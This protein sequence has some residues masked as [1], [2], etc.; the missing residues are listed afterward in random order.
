MS[1]NH[2]F[3]ATF[4]EKLALF[5]SL[6]RDHQHRDD[7]HRHMM[8]QASEFRKK[9]LEFKEEGARSKLKIESSYQ[10][11][12]SF[13]GAWQALIYN[14]ISVAI[15]HLSTCAKESNL[16]AIMILASI[17]SSGIHVDKDI[18]KSNK[19]YMQAAELGHPVAQ[20]NL[21]KSYYRG[22]GY[23]KNLE[24]ALSYFLRAANKSDPESM[25]FLG[26]MFEK[27][28]VVSKDIDRANRYYE[29]SGCRLSRGY[30]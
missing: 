30:H 1:Q 3:M 24:L 2:D 21:G 7:I 10:A 26:E 18:D 4:E 6:L 9:L 12:D 5:E 14:E 8:L 19:L 15:W 17:Y 25:Y 11:L 23:E 29:L 28:L 20:R 22:I 27:G 13:E 16:N